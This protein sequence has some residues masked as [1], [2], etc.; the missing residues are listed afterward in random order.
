MK[1][2]YDVIVV[3][4]GPAGTMAAIQAARAGADTLLVEKNGIL[5]GTTT[6]GGV[7]FPGLFHARGRQVIAGIGWDLVVAVKR[8]TNEPMPNFKADGPHWRHQ[9]HVDAAIF[10][11][12]CDKAVLESGAELLLH[13]MP[14]E[15]SRE[16]DR[17]LLTVCTKTGLHS[18]ETKVLIDATG[19]ANVV[20]LAGFEVVR[21]DEFQPGT[22]AMRLGGYEI[23]KLD[24]PA[25]ER[26]LDKA[27][28]DGTVKV[29]DFGWHRE[30]AIR[31]LLASRGHNRNHITTGRA[32]T[33]EGKTVAEVA[34][35]ASMLRMYTFLRAQ[36]GLEKL[37]LEYV[38]TEVGIRETVVIRG[39]K[40][41][42][43][44]DYIIGRQWDDAVCHSFYPIDIHR[45]QGEPLD[46]RPLSPG[47]FPTIPR[48]A[49]LPA[50]SRGMVVAGRCISGDREAHSAY[51][52][53]ASCMAMG[54]AAGAMA[55]LA[56]QRDCDVEELPI[57][58]VHDLLRRHGAIVP[59][60]VH[61]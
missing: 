28:T 23:D 31:G 58:D 13:A 52:V 35:R 16:G 44:R 5:G 15:V 36:P 21:P 12:L 10:A 18:T 3:G 38:A 37:T 46:C 17:W 34:A 8:I 1:D 27:I 14:A 7:N 25:I 40:T 19:D 43:G 6:M 47:V 53:Q 45:D 51:R 50:G 60:D 30:D 26:A 24:I 49:M 55:A 32:D 4:G 41:I 56:A 48:G 33:S 29:T 39:K 59:G 20:Q 57:A 2:A 54:Q 42:T 61:S 9:V 11:A 22:L